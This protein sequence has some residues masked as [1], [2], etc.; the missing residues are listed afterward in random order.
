MQ[1]RAIHTRI[2]QIQR[3]QRAEGKCQIFAVNCPFKGQQSSHIWR[4]QYSH[5][6]VHNV[7]SHTHKLSDFVPNFFTATLFRF[8][9]GV[10]KSSEAFS[11]LSSLL[12]EQVETRDLAPHSVCL[13]RLGNT[14]K[15]QAGNR[16]NALL[17]YKHLSAACQ[18]NRQQVWNDTP[19]HTHM[20]TGLI[21]IY[22]L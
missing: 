21:V 3:L 4:P 14:Y 6:A 5:T 22:I 16:M 19:T 20:C 12:R 10:P 7:R 13:H 17:W 15:Y 2:I 9:L 18:S 1:N 11:H 8:L